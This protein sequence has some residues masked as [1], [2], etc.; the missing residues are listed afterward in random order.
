ME[1]YDFRCHQAAVLDIVKKGYARGAGHLSAS[2]V[3]VEAADVVLE[4]AAHANLAAHNGSEL[5]NRKLVLGLSRCK[6]VFL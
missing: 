5:A 1:E 6:L 3:R 2:S 4:R